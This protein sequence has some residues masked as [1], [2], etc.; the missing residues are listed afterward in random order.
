MWR[1]KSIHDR[2]IESSNGTGNFVN[3]RLKD[4]LDQSELESPE[5]NWS[6]NFGSISADQ[7]PAIEMIDFAGGQYQPHGKAGIRCYS[8]AKNRCS[9]F[10]KFQ[11]LKASLS[12]S[13]IRVGKLL[14]VCP[15]KSR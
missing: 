14:E 13:V 1:L 5:L 8:Y 15:H 11:S 7:E 10:V 12:R 9:G 2:C 6:T 3:K 4:S